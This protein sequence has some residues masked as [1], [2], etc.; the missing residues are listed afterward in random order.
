M[1]TIKQL[2]REVR[3]LQQRA[4]RATIRLNKFRLKS[5]LEG[6]DDS[7]FVYAGSWMGDRL[8]ELKYDADTQAQNLLKAKAQLKSR[9]QQNN[10]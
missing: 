6:Y 1:T 7:S 9:R 10:A 8:W 2:Q 4:R 5:K 3:R